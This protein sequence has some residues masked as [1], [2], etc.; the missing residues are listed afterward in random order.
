MEIDGSAKE[1]IAEIQS[2]MKE[3]GTPAPALPSTSSSTPVN[4]SCYSSLPTMVGLNSAVAPSPDPSSQGDYSNGSADISSQKQDSSMPVKFKCGYCF[5][6][7]TSRNETV[8]HVR[9][10]HAGK[11]LRI[12]VNIN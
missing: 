8:R 11:I 6:A 10:E 5:Y 9:S 7:S 1:K 4:N 2:H 12:Q 3:E